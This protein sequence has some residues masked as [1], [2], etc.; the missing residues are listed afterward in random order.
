MVREHQEIDEVPARIPDEKVL[1]FVNEG[2]LNPFSKRD[3]RSEPPMDSDFDAGSEVSDVSDFSVWKDRR[4]DDRQDTDYDLDGP[5]YNSDYDTEPDA[6]LD[7]TSDDSN[8]SDDDSAVLIWH[9]S[10][11]FIESVLPRAL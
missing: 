6:E 4:P 11:R 7:G 5:E 2:G 9:R 1:R 10:G 3:W 8:R